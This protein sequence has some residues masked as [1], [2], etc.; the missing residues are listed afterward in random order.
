VTGSPGKC[1]TPNGTGPSRSEP[2][3]DTSRRVGR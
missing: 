1:N 3:D 2:C